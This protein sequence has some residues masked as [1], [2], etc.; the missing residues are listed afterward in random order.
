MSEATLAALVLGATYLALIASGRETNTRRKLIG[1]GIVLGLLGAAAYLTKPEGLAYFAVICLFILILSGIKPRARI[2]LAT[3][4]VA[5]CIIL[6]APYVIYLSNHFDKFTLSGKDINRQLALDRNKGKANIFYIPVDDGTATYYEKPN[7]FVAP[8]IEKNLSMYPKNLN[9]QFKHFKNQ[10]GNVGMVLL[11]IGLVLTGLRNRKLL[12]F[13]L[14]MICIPLLMALVFP[15][16]RYWMTVLPFI[17]ILELVGLFYLC[18]LATTRLPEKIRPQS[19]GS[20]TILFAGLVLALMVIQAQ[21]NLHSLGKA[22]RPSSS[23]TCRVQMREFA[24]EV[25]SKNPQIKGQAL[26]DTRP[27]FAFYLEA[28]P[29]RTPYFQQPEQLV[30]Y[31]KHNNIQYYFHGDSCGLKLDLGQYDPLAR[32][33]LKFG[34]TPVAGN[35]RFMLFKLL[36]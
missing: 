6:A 20:K 19:S 21:W 22:N 10:V 27:W 9:Q 17:Y 26:L 4:A 35:Q 1:N 11:I 28:Q 33:P 30:S 29:R 15:G 32:K 18:N 14:A 24:Q 12:L 5:T 2:F 34:L 31:M 23:K 7:M 13:F 36:N 3:T 25:I 8:P 16:R